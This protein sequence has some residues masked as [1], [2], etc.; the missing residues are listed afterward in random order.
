MRF[1]IYDHDEDTSYMLLDADCIIIFFR[2]SPD[3]NHYHCTACYYDD[4]EKVFNYF[5][6]LNNKQ[7]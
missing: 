4:Y 3:K 1:Y 5:D 7:R 2:E 6:P